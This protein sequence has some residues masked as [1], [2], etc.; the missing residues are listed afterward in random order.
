LLVPY[1]LDDFDS[2]AG[3][4]RTRLTYPNDPGNQNTA[5]DSEID[6]RSLSLFVSPSGGQG[7]E[8]Q[9]RHGGAISF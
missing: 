4:R 9:N 7:A 6:N 5:A 3:L 2:A 8:R 1:F